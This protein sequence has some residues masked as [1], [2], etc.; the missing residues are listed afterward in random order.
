MDASIATQA[1]DHVPMAVWLSDKNGT[2]SWVNLAGCQLLGVSVESLSGTTEDE[3]LKNNFEQAGEGSQLYR[4]KAAVEGETRWYIRLTQSMD[5]GTQITYWSDATEIMRL[6]NENGQLQRQVESLQTTD[7]LTGLMNERAIKVALEPQ[8]SRSRRYEN[9]LSV[10]LM[11]LDAIN[12]KPSEE[13]DAHDQ[14]LVSLAYFLR[15]QL[16]WVDLIGRINDHEFMLVLPETQEEDTEKLVQKLRDRMD[17]IVLASDPSVKLN[18]KTSFGI[19]SW[20]KGDDVSLLLKRAFSAL[21]D[22]RE[23]A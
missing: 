16:R 22:A 15:D 5:G 7:A 1:L 18:M 11:S 14:A 8:V 12:D 10:V 13:S 2:I 17:G 23:A 3:L 6:R 21:E 20:R 19:S 4:L 9:P